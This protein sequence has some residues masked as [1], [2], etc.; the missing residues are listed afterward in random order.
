MFFPTPPPPPGGDGGGGV[1]GGELGGVWG[2]GAPPP[3]RPPPPPHSP[4]TP[5]SFFGFFFCFLYERRLPREPCCNQYPGT[6]QESRAVIPRPRRPDHLS[7][8]TDRAF[9]ESFSS[10]LPSTVGRLVPRP[11]LIPPLWKRALSELPMTCSRR[12]RMPEWPALAPP[13]LTVASIH[14]LLPR[15]STR[16]LYKADRAQNSIRY[17]S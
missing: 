1:V 5:P 6:V 15:R 3:H 11:P 4:P 9:A 2:G 14:G 8:L 7:L 17:F 10:P 13:D 16:E 12:H